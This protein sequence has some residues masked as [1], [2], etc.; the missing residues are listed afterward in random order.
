MV[1]RKKKPLRV[2]SLEM[3]ALLAFDSLLITE[4]MAANDTVLTDE[5]GDYSDWIEIH[6]PTPDDVS[7]DGWSLSDD[8]ELITR[9]RFPDVLLPAGEFLVVFASGKD[10]RDADQPLHANFRL[11]SEGESAVLVNSA[12][13]LVDVFDFPAQQ[14]DQSYGRPVAQTS[15]VTPETSVRW[16][17]PISADADLGDGWTAVGFDDSLWSTGQGAVGFDSRPGFPNVG[18]ES[19]DFTEWSTTGELF[20]ATSNFGVMPTQGDQQALAVATEAG[21]SRFA[22]ETFL[23]LGRSDLNQVLPDIVAT[24]GSALKR[25]LTVEAGTEIQFDWNFVTNE[26]SVDGT[27]DFAFV[28]LSPG[29]LV[30][31]LATVADADQATATQ[32]DRETGYST[33]TLTIT[34]AGD[35]TLGVGVTNEDGRFRASGLLVDNFRING[36]GSI[37]ETFNGILTTRI[38]SDGP[39]SGLWTRHEFS[40]DDVDAIRGLQLPIRYDD[41]YVAYLNGQLLSSSNAPSSAVW[42]AT[43]LADRPDELAFEFEYVTAPASLLQNGA[44]VLAIQGL[45]SGADDVNLMLEAQLIGLGQLVEGTLF[46]S[47]ATPGR[48]N[49]SDSF[50][51]ASV[52][53][54]SSPRGFY[55]EPFELEL[56][57]PTPGA[58]IRYTL[59]GSIPDAESMLYSDPITISKTETVRAF[60]AADGLQ[61]SSVET[62]TYLFVEDVI[63]QSRDT[64]QSRGFPSTWAEN[65]N[66]PP[67]NYDMDQRIVGQNGTDSFGGQYADSIRDDLKS[68]PSLSIVMEIDDLFGPTG[69]YSNQLGRGIL[70][71]RPTSVELIQPDGSEGFQIDAGIRIQGGVSRVISSKMS[72]RLLFKDDYGASKLQY[73]LFGNDPA[74]VFDSVSL[75]ASSGE[76]LVG[77]HYI[78]DEFA[79]RSQLTTGNVASHGNYMHVYINGIY[80]GMYNPVER[81][82]AQ[83]GVNYY[84]GEKEEYDVYNAG[85][86]QGEQVTAIAGSMDSWNQLIQLSEEVANARTEAERTAAYMKLQGRNLDG[87]RNPDWEVY[88]DADNFID[89]LITQVYVRNGDWPIRN[90]YMLRRSGP[91]STGF[92]F[93]VWDAEFS[94]D[95]GRNASPTSITPDGPGLV[96][97]ALDSSE[98]FRVQFSD[99]VQQHFAPGGAYYVNPE[100]PTWDP[101]RPAD[102]VPAALYASLVSEIFSPLAAE[103]A[104]WGDD[105]AFRPNLLIRDEE[106]LATALFNLQSFFPTRSQTLVDELRRIEFYRD[107][108]TFSVAGGRVDTGTALEIDSGMDG[109]VYY[110]LDGTDPRMPDGTLSP[111]AIPYDGPIEIR[112]RVTVTAR[113]VSIDRWTAKASSQYF[114][115]VA[116]VD[117]DS[118]RIAEVNYNPHDAR[119]EIGELNVDND[120]FEF[121]EIVNVSDGPLDL[122]GVR[123]VSIDGEGVEFQFGDQTLGFGQRVVIPRD[124]E[125]FLSRYG[126]PTRLARGIGSDTS[127]WAY[128]GRLR[129]SSERITLQ[130]PNGATIQRLVYSDASPWPLRSDGG[131]SS[132][133]VVAL[134]ADLDDPQNYRASIQIGGS[135]GDVGAADTGEVRFNEVIANPSEGEL[136]QVELVKLDSPAIDIS[137]WYLSDDI[138]DLWKFRVPNNTVLLSDDVVVFDAQQLG[139]GISSTGESLYLVSTDADGQTPR[140]VDTVRFDGADTDVSMGRWPNRHGAFVPLDQPSLGALNAGPRLSDVIVSEIHHAP[141]DPDAQGPLTG[142]ATEFVELHNRSEAV[143]DLSGW[144]LRGD[145]RYTIPNGTRLDPGASIIVTSFDANADA[146]RRTVFELTFGVRTELRFLGPWQGTLGDDSGQVQLMKPLGVLDEQGEPTAVSLAE[147]IDY[148]SSTTWPNETLD[149][150][151]SIQRRSADLFAGFGGSWRAARVTPGTTEFVNLSVGDV[152]EDG[153][154]DAQDIDHLCAGIRQQNSFA[155]LDGDGQIDVR[156]LDFLLVDILGVAP[157]DADLNGQFDSDDFVTVMIAGEYN[158]LLPLNSTWADGDWNCDGE[159]DDADFVRAFIYGRY[160]TADRLAASVASSQRPQSILLAAAIDNATQAIGAPANSPHTTDSSLAPLTSNMTAPVRDDH[161]PLQLWNRRPSAVSVDRVFV[162]AEFRE[163]DPRIDTYENHRLK[164]NTIAAELDI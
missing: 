5:D 112:D 127:Q 2:E 71:E 85:D 59:D 96:Y 164:R 41:G 128:Q 94:L 130:T 102:N 7:L 104:R 139:F 4:L 61:P 22:M 65:P 117:V 14:G 162:D 92:K 1:S 79:R 137:G 51:F 69:I 54:F 20:V 154:V 66:S 152:T 28:T 121:I 24:T 45:R 53:Q 160:A 136:D 46:L 98:A 82:D 113:N 75:R 83:F 23:G 118:L 32:F 73:P 64:A 153:S 76:H 87:S 19:G 106:W 156:D 17:V 44:N 140:F 56:A 91:D 111:T 142:A 163:S 88:L 105:S 144:Q 25:E 13:E 31:P 108:P 40:V 97:L 129:N 95:Q 37:A 146:T 86:F 147:A 27:R 12:S 134:N 3:R 138:D 43:A 30:V 21:T 33:H 109:L 57:T 18:F 124:R 39:P 155:D 62:Q 52:V 99:R 29:N 38:E 120:A 150:G 16:R 107:A 126:D 119:T 93:F 90:Y 114:T 115:D 89:Y 55:D 110:T 15:Y 161:R 60:A 80:W 68:I 135:P 10:R 158:D 6:N 148:R 74:A 72:L 26:P 50:S 131:G 36:V 159:F 9:W 11:A 48:A 35:Y 151:Q 49:T 143:A 84:G 132:L 47:P 149:T 141:L 78:R 122:N 42:D 8:R 70:W 58:T 63:T 133:E 77:I 123:L 81:I 157:G 125:A 67:V 103:T 101:E 116:P 34:E 145:V 100:N